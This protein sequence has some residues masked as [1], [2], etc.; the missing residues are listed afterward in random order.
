[1][2]ELSS[3]VWLRSSTGHE[4]AV[5]YATVRLIWILIGCFQR[6]SNSPLGNVRRSPA[7]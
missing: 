6:H 1:M 7:S 4:L 2:I 3:G 5:P